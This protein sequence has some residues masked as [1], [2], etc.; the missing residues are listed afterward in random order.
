MPDELFSFGDEP[1]DAVEPVEETSS[2]ARAAGWQVDLLRGLLDA[3]GYSSMTDRQRAIEAVV[4]RPVESLRALTRGEALLAAEEL[5]T[6][7]PPRR[8]TSTWDDR[9]ENTWIDRL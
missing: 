5:G 6:S 2:A 8:S 7:A 9:D 1:S 4:G 3:R